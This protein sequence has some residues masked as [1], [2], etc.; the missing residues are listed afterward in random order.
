MPDTVYTT[1]TA[2]PVLVK[3]IGTLAFILTL[4]AGLRNLAVSLGAGIVL[5]AIWSG[6]S[7][8]KSV[9]VAWE[10]FSSL[11]NI[12]LLIIV[13]LVIWLSN[14]MK[15][16]GVMSSLV[17]SVRER[18]SHR[19]TIAAL[20]AII[21][22]LPMPGGA[23]F[24]APLV[25]DCDTEQNIEPLLKTR[26]NYWFRH[27]WEYWWPLYPGVLLAIDISGVDIWQFILV[28][29][30]MSILAIAVGYWFML[31]KL[32]AP[33]TSK[34]H[35][36][37]TTKS[38][39]IPLLAPILTVVAVYTVVRLVLPELSEYAKYAPMVFG[40]CAGILLLQ[41]Q[42]PLGFADWKKII[43]S[44]RTAVLAILVA[45]VRI[46]G[47]FIEARLPDGNLL[48]D[49]MR[50]EMAAWGVPMLLVLMALPF[51][52]G[53]ATGLSVGFVGASFP[54]VFTLI[55]SDPSIGVLLA[56]VVLA[57]GFGYMGMILSPVHICLIVTNEHFRTRLLHS[58]RSLGLP[59]LT[60]LLTV[61]A[62]YFCIL[63]L[64]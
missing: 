18:L 24:S 14:M 5:L 60:V 39:L 37:S 33:S 34:Q 50:I 44:K 35:E 45:L 61:T 41:F 42:R 46:Y 2:L 36:K 12:L 4:N 22:M 43:F 52:S 56:T 51:L 31:R 15:T 29:M 27:V 6:H 38:P 10:K 16:T 63:W 28:Q 64:L 47:A 40:L 23:I 48:I 54:V 3:V 30:P 13:F 1:F 21:G 55:G 57:Y 53:L 7:A 49:Q 32:S 58:I 19:T 8:A 11:D 25:D 9:E 26:I 20:P 62:V 17:L 59:A